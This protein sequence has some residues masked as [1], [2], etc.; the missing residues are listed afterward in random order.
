MPFMTF[1]IFYDTYY[2]NLRNIFS[3][4]KIGTTKM[5]I[6]A[7]TVASIS[8]TSNELL[9]GNNSLIAESIITAIHIKNIVFFEKCTFETFF[10]E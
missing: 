8:Y 2:C 3:F 4:K 7:I 9:N 6:S 10:L 1:F 5:I